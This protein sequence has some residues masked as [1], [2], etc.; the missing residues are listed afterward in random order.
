MR[1]HLASQTAASF[2]PG[3]ELHRASEGKKCCAPGARPELTEVSS[4]LAAACLSLCVWKAFSISS[5]T[6]GSSRVVM[7]PRSWTP[8]VT[9]FLSSRRM[10]FPE[11]VLGRR[12]TTWQHVWH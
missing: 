9:I 6:L 4:Y 5:T 12:F 2:I 11:R 10:T 8:P 1:C 7:S 3:Y